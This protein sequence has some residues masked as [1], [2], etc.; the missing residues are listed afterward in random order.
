M[1]TGSSKRNNITEI[2][3]A[4]ISNSGSGNVFYQGGFVPTPTIPINGS[5]LPNPHPHF[6]GRQDK[7]Q[8][9]MNALSSRAWIIGIDG[10]GGIGKTTLA[11][12]V[13]HICKRSDSSHTNVPHF[14]GYIWT[15][16][17]DKPNFCLDDVVREILY[18]L[19]P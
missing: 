2:Q 18:V 17:R 5:N 13:A 9:V 10:M 1:S 6:V 12:E 8:E 4:T 15:S 7:I 19:S 16:A 14:K 3:H 11:L